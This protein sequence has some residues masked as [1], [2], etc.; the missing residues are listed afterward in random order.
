MP[1]FMF[2]QAGTGSEEIS[3]EN[4]LQWKAG[5]GELIVLPA[6]ISHKVDVT[7]DQETRQW[8][9]VNYF[10]LDNVDLFNFL[11]V[12]VLIKNSIGSK[13]GEII[14]DWVHRQAQ[15]QTNPLLLAVKQH[16]FSLSLLGVLIPACHW[17]SDAQEK[18]DAVR[19]LNPVIQ[20]MQQH[21][22]QSMN[23][24]D[25]ARMSGLSPAQFHVVF[26]ALLHSTPM[27]YLRNLRLRHAQ[28]LLIMTPH[29]VQEIG[30]RSGY[31][32]PFVFCKFFKRACGLSPSEYR[33]RTQFMRTE[34]KR[35]RRLTHEFPPTP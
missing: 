5:T 34:P 31:E 2:S 28:R 3:L 20:H 32:D 21:L 13:T 4:G 25:L 15:Y 10:I 22:G 19:R 33:E 11:E 26:R 23:R 17:K 29:S 35:A 16:E 27:D 30:V 7:S 14:S 9:H 1:F 8:A 6:G 12:P 24:N 18:V